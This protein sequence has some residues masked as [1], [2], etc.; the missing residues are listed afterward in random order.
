[1]PVLMAWSIY[2]H[3][4]LY[5][6]AMR[7]SYRGEYTERY[8][9]LGNA[10]SVPSDVLEVCSGDLALHDHLRR[11]G[12]LRSYRGLD[13]SSAMV[14]R[15]RRRGVHVEAADLRAVRQLP[16]AEVVVMQASLYQFHTMADSLLRLLWETAERQLLIAEP[17]HNLSTSGN[18][19]V[20]RVGQLL[21]QTEESPHPFRYTEE[22]LRELYRR[23]GVPLT[24]VGRTSHGRELI[25]SSLKAPAE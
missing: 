8:T 21:S 19:L 18:A 17:V 15:A 14:A 24:R 3:P 22:T 16:R 25:V 10:L 20:R 6:L 11:R 12:L 23:C 1:M 13:I 9:L 4:S 2:R 7:V 5:R